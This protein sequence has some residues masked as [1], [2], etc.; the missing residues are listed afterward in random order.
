MTVVCAWN[1]FY[2]NRDGVSHNNVERERDTE[3]ILI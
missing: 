1:T 3:S 2:N